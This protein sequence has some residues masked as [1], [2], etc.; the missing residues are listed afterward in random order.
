MKRLCISEKG[1]GLSA[2]QVGVPWRLFIVVKDLKNPLNFRYL[3]D[4]KYLPVDEKKVASIEGCLS[5][6]NSNGDFRRFKVDR[7]KN[8]DIVGKEMLV[9]DKLKLVDINER[10]YDNLAII[11]QHEIDHTSGITID[12]IGQEIS[13]W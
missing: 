10:C 13:I 2:I 8:I 7:Y 6:R 9:D 4:C 1:V 5:I 12:Q 3:V 11:Y